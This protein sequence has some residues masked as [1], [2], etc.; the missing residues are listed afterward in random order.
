MTCFC[1][2]TPVFNPVLLLAMPINRM[3]KPF[4]IDGKFNII[5]GQIIDNRSP[6][7]YNICKG[8]PKMQIIITISPIDY[9]TLPLNYNYAVQGL[10]YSLLNSVPEYARFLHDIGYENESSTFKLF[11]FGGIKGDYHIENR[12]IIPDGNISFEIRSVSEEFCNIMKQALLNTETV[13]LLSGEYRLRMIEVYDKHITEP[14]ICVVTS[15]PIVAKQT[16]EDGQT[17]YYSPEDDDFLD[18]VNANYGR[19]I[20]AFT[21]IYP[22][23]GVIVEPLGRCRKIVTK[24][25]G[26]WVTAYHGKFRLTGEPMA[27]DFLYQTGLGAKSSQ[28][29]GMFDLI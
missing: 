9:K 12:Q 29:F 8:V 22:E 3:V 26:L 28:G 23:Y 2:K 1:P 15:S 6:I 13:R 7:I 19:K 27:L 10:I 17:V 4:E 21:G 16:D 25:K 14:E 11:T 24:F 18:I 20:E 5:F